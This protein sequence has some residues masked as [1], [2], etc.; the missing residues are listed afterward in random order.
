M[1]VFNNTFERL[2]DRGLVVY[3]GGDSEEVKLRLMQDVNAAAR[4]AAATNRSARGR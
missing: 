1:T 4:I 3:V 2:T